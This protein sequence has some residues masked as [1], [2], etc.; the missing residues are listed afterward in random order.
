MSD[1]TI[2]S[3]TVTMDSREIVQRTGKDHRNVMRDIREMFDA[4]GKPALIFECS[5]VRFK[6]TAIERKWL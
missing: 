2:L 4:L 6:T 3:E 1:L 5:Y